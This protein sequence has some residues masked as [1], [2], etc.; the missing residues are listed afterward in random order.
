MQARKKKEA[1]QKKIL[2]ALSARTKTPAKLR[3][4]LVNKMKVVRFFSVIISE[5]VVETLVK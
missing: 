5:G 3:T 4:V 1:G 2:K